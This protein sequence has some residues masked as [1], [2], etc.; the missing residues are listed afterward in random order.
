MDKFTDTYDL[1]NLNKN[2]KYLNRPIKTSKIKMIIKNL[3]KKKK[4]NNK[5]KPNNTVN[6]L[7]RDNLK[8][9]RKS[10]LF[11]GD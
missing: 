3:Q 9:G 11:I 2:R 10:L 8:N 1:P 4:N 5:N 7:N 6:N